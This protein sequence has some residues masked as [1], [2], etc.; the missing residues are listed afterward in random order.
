MRTA[1]PGQAKLFPTQTIRGRY[2]TPIFIKTDSKRIV[3]GLFSPEQILSVGLSSLIKEKHAGLQ[4]LD[5]LGLTLF[6]VSEG[7]DVEINMNFEDYLFIQDQKYGMDIVKTPKGEIVITSAIVEQTGWI[8]VDKEAWENIASPL[9]RIT[10]NAPLIILPILVLSILA[11]WF[12]I[13]QI[14][15]PLQQLESKAEDLA[16][17]NFKT[18][19]KP[20]GGIP[21]IKNLQYSMVIMANKLKFAQK[22]L[23]RYIGSITNGI[24]NERRNLAREL[25]DDTLQTLIALGQNSQYAKHW[26]EDPKVGI[27]LDQ[28]SSLTDEGIKNLR[29]LLQGLRP[30]Y[31]EDLGLT[32]ALSMLA[33]N[34][35]N[36]NGIKVHFQQNGVERRLKPDVEM[37]LYRIAQEALN[38]AFR[39]AKAKNIWINIDFHENDVDIELRD[40]GIGFKIPEDSFHFAARGHFGLLGMKERADLIGAKLHIESLRGK[41][42][43]VSVQ[44][45]EKSTKDEKKK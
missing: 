20:V 43:S 39:H 11:L 12:G 8:L 23:Q 25:H 10:Q 19:K 38:N 33:V 1:S 2:F 21:E 44:Y 18:I 7:S 28:I 17:G 45:L 30:I 35:L 29:G 37:T 16:K 31:I 6:Q 4:V 36:P 41:G 9:L 26:N 5:N 13:H 14:V 27:S 34:Q 42:T 15:Q 22:N 3:A 40:D 24:E 32:T